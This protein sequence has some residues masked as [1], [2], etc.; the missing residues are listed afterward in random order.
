MNGSHFG[1]QRPR[2]K[3]AP[4]RK[5]RLC[6]FAITIAVAALVCLFFVLDKSGPSLLPYLT[7]SHITDK[8]PDSG[9]KASGVHYFQQ[10]YSPCAVLADLETGK[11]L[12]EHNSREKIYPASLTKI[13]TAILAIE[14]TEDLNGTITLPSGFFEKLYVEDAS[15]AGFEPGEE[16]LLKD[17]LYGILLPSGAEC[18]LA[19][20]ENISGSEEAFTE[21]M[22]QKAKAL[23]MENTHF[24]NSTGLHNP[25]HYSTVEDI[26]ILLQY[27]L[28]NQ[29]FR[30]AFTSQSYSTA[31]SEQHPQGFTF[32]STMFKYLD[33]A[34][35]AGGEI[36]GGKTGYTEEAGLC[37]AS[38]A[39][40][41]GMEYILVT[42]KAAVGTHAAAENY[43]ILDAISVYNQLGEVN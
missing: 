11:T 40:I 20:A 31:P 7:G 22:N 41:N 26:L 38:L 25:N 15:M 29:V 23:G 39:D 33:S 18:C 17:L 12:A 8:T 21:L 24:C 3:K 42:A 6:F 37:L 32:Y 1:K 36:L 30:A 13:M 2:S 14:N 27:A 5:K 34:E 28:K 9:S 16:V 4:K 43:H 10:L 19:F 35:V